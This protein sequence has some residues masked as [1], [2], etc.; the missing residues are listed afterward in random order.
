MPGLV[1]AGALVV[2]KTHRARRDRIGRREK[3]DVQVGHAGVA[4]VAA[5]ADDVAAPDARARREGDGV[6][7]QVAKLRVLAGCSMIT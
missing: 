2:R 7:G 6:R 4:G 5:A 1:G 3:T